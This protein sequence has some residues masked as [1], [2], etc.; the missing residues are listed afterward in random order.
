MEHGRPTG[1]GRWYEDGGELRY[2]GGIDYNN[3]NTGYGRWY[4]AD[5]NKLEGVWKERKLVD[6]KI[7][8]D[9]KYGTHD[10]YEVKDNKK[11]ACI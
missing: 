11:G 10:C 1:L 9:N 7:Y 6:G 3:Y 2:V 5:G 4:N 8:T